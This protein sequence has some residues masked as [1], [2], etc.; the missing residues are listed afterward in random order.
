MV[1]GV[2]NLP[3]KAGLRIYLCY[4][5]DKYNKGLMKALKEQY[6][7]DILAVIKAQYLGKTVVN[8]LSP[9]GNWL[10]AT[11][12][13]IEQ[14]KA[15]LS[16][17]IRPEMGNPYGMIHGGMLMVLIDECI[18]W[19]V[20]S[21]NANEHYTSVNLDTDFLYMA[22]VGSVIRAE[23]QVVRFGKKICNVR[24]EVFDADRN[25]LASASS[26][27]VHTSRNVSIR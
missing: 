22:P 18:G 10:Q 13:H 20:L 24:V 23:A 19:A 7:E 1:W 11:L 2:A 9:A 12:E 5:L 3:K 15:I 6:G 17:T 8:S 27:L 16:I 21:M 14:G 26:N 4:L 25:I